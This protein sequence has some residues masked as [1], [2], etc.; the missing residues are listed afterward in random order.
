MP[1]QDRPTGDAIALPRPPKG[2]VD[3]AERTR[4]SGWA[5]DA[6]DPDRPLVVELVEGG[7]VLARTVANLPRPDLRDA[8]LGSGDHGFSF[9][10]PERL[11]PFARHVVR[12]RAA[13]TDI[14][15]PGSPAVIERPE[16]EAHDAD[17][18]RR[19]LHRRIEAIRS[20][21]DLG[22]MVGLL[23]EELDH[24]FS[25]RFRVGQPVLAPRHEDAAA[26]GPPGSVREAVA[27]LRERYG[28]IE[29]P[30]VR[31]P[32]VSI[33]VVSRDQFAEVH[34]CIAALA[35]AAPRVPCEIVL[36]DNCSTDET[37]V[38]RAVLP[39][40]VRI[41][42]TPERVS[43]V[44]A[45]RAG[46]A[47]ASGRLVLFLH[48]RARLSPGSI[49]AMV[50]AF[51]AD[52]TVGAVG[53][54][55]ENPNGTIAAAG[56]AVLA[57]GRLAGVGEGLPKDHPA[58]QVRQA[59]DAVLSH[60][61]MIDRA[62][63][64]RVGGPDEACP[65]SPHADADLALRIRR[66]G[67]RVVVET[68]ARA[69]LAIDPDT[70]VAGDGFEE[71]S[72]A[73]DGARRL[74]AGWAE[75]LS[76][77]LHA[78]DD[79]LLH[80]PVKR[81][82]VID[83]AYPAPHVDAGSAAVVSHIRALRDL[84]HQVL[85]IP[86]GPPEGPPDAVR[87]LRDLGV[88]CY[89]QPFARGVEDLLAREGGRL[90]AIYIHRFANA[91][92]Y[93]D[94]CR[95]LAPA[96]HIVFSLADLHFLRAEREAAVR[97]EAA[98]PAAAAALRSEEL[99]LAARAD[100][101]I[102]HSSYEAGLLAEAVPEAR[103]HVVPWALAARPVTRPFAERSGIAFI[104]SYQHAPN[105]DAARWLVDEIMPLV[106]QEA[107]EIVLHLVGAGL[108]PDVV[109]PGDGVIV[110]GWVEDLH[111][112]VF[113]QVRLTV[114]PLRFGAGLKGKVLDSLASGVA[115]LMTPCAAEGLPRITK[116]QPWIINGPEA[117]ARA[118][119]DQHKGLEATSEA[120]EEAR[121]VIAAFTD[122][123][124]VASALSAALAPSSPH[125]QVQPA[126]LG[127]AQRE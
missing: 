72:R 55:I 9:A 45:L 120:L 103:V 126:A 37:I 113:S 50:G 125:H 87:L 80:P 64:A 46:Q 104:G 39:P 115:C 10:T 41:F 23:A 122:P 71:R 78:S 81:V 108:P 75:I 119:I 59:A 62:L 70:L 22:A 76:G 102:T 29:L 16:A 63:W 67:R 61:A 24:A 6:A 110:R 30:A 69:V 13:G 43:D 106:R 42:R 127:E 114:A 79:P 97:G 99:A 95:R 15:L 74:R 116:L 88:E 57:N 21:D 123:R 85:F 94:A 77:P 11:F 40:S 36:C 90:D 124:A 107:P 73:A 93:L 112:D 118:I 19:L 47:L 54:V 32:V 48:A 52:A 117:F 1:D 44:R 98:D 86:G 58:V 66:A 25:Q 33:V 53:A 84:G 3:V 2:H 51:E 89:H 49:D 105:V 7:D 17:M 83:H 82:L 60:A 34:A 56:V 5:Q 101:V 68:D 91:R 35:A 38:A 26:A 65:D 4:I 28:E 109:G 31:K 14:D 20:P 8:G 96:A 92:G 12:V 121:R 100:A 27:R 111:E 18:L